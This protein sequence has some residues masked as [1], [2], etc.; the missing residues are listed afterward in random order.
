LDKDKRI[1][2]T[3]PLPPAVHAKATVSVGSGGMVAS[4][5]LTPPENGG[6]EVSEE[7]IRITLINKNVTFGVDNKKIAALV[8]KPIYYSAQ[9]VAEGIHP[10][11]G[12]NAAVRPLIRT[13]KDRRPKELDD[14]T[15]D[16]KN[17]G[18][19][20]TVVK[21][22]VLCEKDPP[23][24]GTPGTNVY[25]NEVPAR[26]GK[27][28]PLPAGKNTVV[29]E[30]GLKLLATCDGHA[31]IVSKKIQVLNALTI[32]ESIS[33]ATGNIDYLGH[34]VINGNVL[35]GF[36]VKATG[37]ITISGTVEGANIE[38][39]GSIIIQEGV[40]G[41]GKGLVKAGGSLKSKYIQSGNVRTAGD[42]ETSFI[43]HSNVQ[44]GGNIFLLGSK[45]TI[46]GGEVSALRSIT[47][48]LIGGRNSY[49][50]T[51]VEVGNDPSTLIRSRE[52]PKEIETIKKEA[53][54]IVRT[55]RLLSEHKKAGRITP[56]KMET[57][58]RSISSYQKMEVRVKELEAEMADV[59]EIIE[60]A[61]FG[62]LNITGTIYPGVR[63]VIGPENL[64]V[65]DK[66][67]RCSF[68]RNENGVQ[69]VPL[70]TVSK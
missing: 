49:V 53:A 13:E 64:L 25:G 48:S 32:S 52:I 55:I 50:Y 15:V 39:G 1:D 22:E 51:Q 38:A 12:D 17:L 54:A 42:I 69:M 18:L 61:G 24:Q 34:V 56:D 28:V 40:N 37:N 67:D 36:S 20:Q 26:P 21:D 65:E 29:S 3:Q 5:T 58:Q 9:P 46:V 33:N 57:L 35:T 11:N 4:V 10:V 45:G 8:S 7:L 2:I 16:Y 68:V 30:D 62:S 59:N 43:L 6:F 60:S 19:I 47:T 66:Y 41:F 27:D 44:S 14:G 23:T 70:K 31:D 63:I